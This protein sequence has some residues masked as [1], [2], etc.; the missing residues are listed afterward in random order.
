MDH[1]HDTTPAGAVTGGLS[2]LLSPQRSQKLLGLGHWLGVSV[3][4][5]CS[6]GWSAKGEE[7]PLYKKK[8][9]AWSSRQLCLPPQSCA[10]R[11]QAFS[12]QPWPCR[13][14]P[15]RA[16]K[17]GGA[18]KPCRGVCLDADAITRKQAKLGI[19]RLGRL[20]VCAKQETWRNIC[21]TVKR[22]RKKVEP[23]ASH[24]HQG[25]W[26]D[27]SDSLGCLMPQRVIDHAALQ[28]LGAGGKAVKGCAGQTEAL[29]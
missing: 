20:R 26:Q 25:M 28:C 21:L 23:F 14:L 22:E 19:A 15:S 17:A 18:E 13:V 11:W 9:E 4:L 6:G 24:E 2:W 10:S 7:S 5:F 3:V 8:K 16:G 12:A 1:I 29:C 27:P